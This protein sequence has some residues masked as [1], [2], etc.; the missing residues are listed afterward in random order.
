MQE[1]LHS[2]LKL[3]HVHIRDTKPTCCLRSQASSHEGAISSLLQSVAAKWNETA[4]T[5]QD[6][7]PEVTRTAQELRTSF[8]SGI[9]SFLEEAQKV[10][11]VKVFNVLGCRFFWGSGL[12]IKCL[13]TPKRLH[14]A[15]SK[16]QRDSTTIRLQISYTIFNPNR[17]E[18]TEDRGRN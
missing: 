3:P 12:M 1:V 16:N 14:F 18:N 9:Q 17:L 7:N 15:N 13:W 10:R 4:T 8:N 5:L 11:H 2:H 6:Q